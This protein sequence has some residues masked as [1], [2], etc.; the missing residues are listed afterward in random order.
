MK[1]VMHKADVKSYG[2]TSNVEVIALLSVTGGS[3]TGF[4][5]W[6]VCVTCDS[7]LCAS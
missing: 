7:P 2:D 6:N 5:S 4:D 1:R 3:L